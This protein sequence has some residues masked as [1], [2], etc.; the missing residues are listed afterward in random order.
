MNEKFF[1]SGGDCKDVS[2]YYINLANKGTELKGD[3]IR[4][5]GGGGDDD[6]RGM[7]NED[8]K[9]SELLRPSKNKLEKSESEFL[10]FQNTKTIRNWV[11]FLD[12][13]HHKQPKCCKLMNQRHRW[14]EKQ[15]LITKKRKCFH[16]NVSKELKVCARL[17][18]A[19]L[20]IIPHHK[21]REDKLKRWQKRYYHFPFSSYSGVRNHK[22]I[23]I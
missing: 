17:N 8:K 1:C 14:N 4:V 23:C 7:Q 22:K 6:C 10:L 2:C 18:V 15:G 9:F 12:S 3:E 21:K 20:S 11:E 5:G 19:T 13:R 16:F